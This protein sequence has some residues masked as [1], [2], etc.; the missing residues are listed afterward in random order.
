[1]RTRA[2]RGELMRLVSSFLKV[3]SHADTASDGCSPIIIAERQNISDLQPTGL[4]TNTH[5]H[6][7]LRTQPDDCWDV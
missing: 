2:T 7:Y 1:M 4:V 5:T 3:S 6:T